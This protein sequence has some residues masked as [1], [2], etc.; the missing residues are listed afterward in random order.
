VRDWSLSSF[1]RN[2]EQGI[3]PADWGGNMRDIA[4]HFGE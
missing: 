2:V 3:L 1:H 4:G